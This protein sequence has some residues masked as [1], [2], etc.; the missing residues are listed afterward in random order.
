MLFRS[1]QHRGAG[2]LV[3]ALMHV[4]VAVL[5]LQRHFGA[6]APDRRKQRLADIQI[7]RVAEFILLRRTRRL[8]ARRPR[9]TVRFCVFRAEPEIM[10]LLGED[11]CEASPTVAFVGRDLVQKPAQ[12]VKREDVLMLGPQL[13]VQSRNVVR[14]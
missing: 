7:Q 12:S 2:T 3:F 1:H 6:L 9:A 10:E 11:L 8:S 4:Q 14:A 5:Q 13:L